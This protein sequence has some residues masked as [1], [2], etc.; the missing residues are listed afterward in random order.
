MQRLHLAAIA[1]LAAFLAAPGLAAAQSQTSEPIRGTVVSVDRNHGTIVLRFAPPGSSPP[2]KRTFALANHNDIL[3]L[4]QGVVID[5]TA[6]TSRTV[7]VL[8]D[9]N[10]ESTHPPKGDVT[11]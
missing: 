4:K 8:S 1:A 6:D 10:I 5:G 3:R 11:Q 2:T 7:W 9:V